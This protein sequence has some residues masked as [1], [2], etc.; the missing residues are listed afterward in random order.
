MGH[1]KAKTPSFWVTSNLKFAT[2][3]IRQVGSGVIT[4]WDFAQRCT[5]PPQVPPRCPKFLLDMAHSEAT[6]WERCENEK[7]RFDV[8]FLASNAFERVEIFFVFDVVGLV[9][10]AEKRR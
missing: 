5:W 6:F 1:P 4:K 9:S 3:L 7:L 2:F 8:V 10:N